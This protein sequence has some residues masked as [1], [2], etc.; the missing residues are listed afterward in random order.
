MAKERKFRSRKRRTKFYDRLSES[1]FIWTSLY[2]R[3]IVAKCQAL[4]RQFFL[5]TSA[6]ERRHSVQRVLEENNLSVRALRA[7]HYSGAYLLGPPTF[8]LAGLF[9]TKRQ[10]RTEHA[11]STERTQRNALGTPTF[12]LACLS[13]TKRQPRTEYTE[14]IERTQRNALGTPTFKLACLEK[15]F[16]TE[17]KDTCQTEVWRSQ[18]LSDVF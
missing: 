9:K 12:K 3:A 18:A 10:F 7:P 2:H 4:F 8:K 17:K 16:R 5:R 15:R 6:Q 1:R 11:E 13:R 14:G